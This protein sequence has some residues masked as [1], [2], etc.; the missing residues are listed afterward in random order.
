MSYFG[1]EN[2]DGGSW[3]YC[4]QDGYYECNAEDCY[5]QGP[6]CPAGMTPGEQP[7]GFDC[8]DSSDCA[9]GCYCGNGTCEEA[10]FCT[11]DTD[12]GNG[13]T[14]NES[15]SSCEPTTQPETSCVTDY[16]CAQGSYCNSAT[17]KCEATCSCTSDAEAAAQMFD[18]C[19]VGRSTCLPGIDP[20]GDCTGEVTCNLGRPSCPEGSVAMIS[21]GCYTGQCQ[22]INTCSEAPG[23]PA[24]TNEMDCANAGSCAL[25]FTGT[26]CHVPGNLNA[27]CTVPGANCVCDSY[28]FASCSDATP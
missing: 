7:G 4:G 23:C 2:D 22:A 20:A 9:A 24:Y 17:L 28:T 27:S 16:D 18:Y 11:Q 3:T 26:N 14:C 15:R 19:D 8:K 12:C 10:G 25:S 21:E 6:E 1:E 13:Y 5:W